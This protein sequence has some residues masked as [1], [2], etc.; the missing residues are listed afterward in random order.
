MFL[1]LAIAFPLPGVAALM[2][3]ARHRPPWTAKRPRKPRPSNRRTP[4]SPVVNVMAAENFTAPIMVTIT[5]AAG[6]RHR[7][8]I[9]KDGV[10]HTDAAMNLN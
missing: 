8:T 5:D 3:R 7:A 2:S 1:L 4:R 10:Q 9:D 6:H